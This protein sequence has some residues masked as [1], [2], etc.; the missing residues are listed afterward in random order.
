[1]SHIVTALS[2]STRD[3]LIALLYRQ[4]TCWDFH[5]IFWHRP[6]TCSAVLTA[7]GSPLHLRRSQH[8]QPPPSLRWQCSSSCLP[9]LQP[10]PPPAL[11]LLLFTVPEKKK[12]KKERSRLGLSHNLVPACAVCMRSIFLVLAPISDQM[13][14]E[15]CGH[16]GRCVR[17]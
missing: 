7:L 16:A 4:P 5:K 12:R 17:V 11:S 14:V 2:L 1:M 9:G 13:S 10:L 6:R 8:Y 15:I 3:N